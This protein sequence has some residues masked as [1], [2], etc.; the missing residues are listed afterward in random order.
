[1]PAVVDK[2]TCTG[3]ESCV[4]VCQSE[5]ISMS[6]DVANIDTDACTD[7]AVCVDECPVD[8]ITMND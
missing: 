8:A 1:M 3:C 2:E 4:D 6:D 7:C 5:A